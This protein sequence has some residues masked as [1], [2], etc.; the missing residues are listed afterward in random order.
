[1]G[2]DSWPGASFLIPWVNKQLQVGR[3]LRPG[4]P[5][6]PGFCQFSV[7][8]ADRWGTL[9]PSELGAFQRWEC[10]LPVRSSG[11]KVLETPRRGSA[12]HL[13]TFCS[14]YQSPDPIQ[15]IL[16]TTIFDLLYPIYFTL[17]PPA[18]YPLVI[19]SL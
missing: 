8:A 4:L 18:P 15:A 19:T 9:R 17:L 3:G 12:S 6:G 11:H 7:K 13:H 2:S 5:L 14:T 16:P 1:M 10:S